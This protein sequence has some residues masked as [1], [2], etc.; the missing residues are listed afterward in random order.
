MRGRGQVS[1]LP[2]I[3]H[4]KHTHFWKSHL[5]PRRWS[6]LAS[7]VLWTPLELIEWWWN[8]LDL[9]RPLH[10]NISILL[11]SL[12]Q[13]HPVIEK[14]WY[15]KH[16][17]GISNCF[18]YTNTNHFHLRGLLSLSNTEIILT[19]LAGLAP[20]TPQWTL[21]YSGP[22]LMKSIWLSS[23]HQSHPGRRR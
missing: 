9:M 19:V 18:T 3:V 10:L 7:W 2:H 12:L 20:V 22:H 14:L 8:P 4:H 6:V 5:V 21:R 13:Q 15:R 16:R 23:P 1:Q 11:I 17:H